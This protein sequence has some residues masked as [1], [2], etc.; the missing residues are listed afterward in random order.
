MVQDAGVYKARALLEKVPWG[1]KLWSLTGHDRETHVGYL[2]G[3]LSNDW[4]GE[5]HINSISL[6]LNAQAKQESGSRP[7]SLVA[8]LD[9]YTYLSFH[10]GATAEAIQTHEGLSAYAKRISDHDF[11]HIFIPAHVGGNHWIVFSMDF[12]KCIFKHGEFA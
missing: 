11:R 4:L 8:D 10:S 3:L 7:K 5:R 12:E 1:L 2:A 9:L 6:Y